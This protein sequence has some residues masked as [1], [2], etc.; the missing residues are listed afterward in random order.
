MGR[1]GGGGGGGGGETGRVDNVMKEVTRI[2]TGMVASSSTF[3]LCTGSKP[4]GWSAICHQAH[5][6]PQW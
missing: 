3:F 6:Y 5:P 4:P 2:A 1:L